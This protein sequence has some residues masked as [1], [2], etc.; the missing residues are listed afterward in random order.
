MANKKFVFQNMYMPIRISLPLKS[1]WLFWG[2]FFVEE[3]VVPFLFFALF[4]FT[5][6]YVII[7]TVVDLHM[8]V[9]I[10]TMYISTQ[11]K[12]WQK[13]FPKP[14][15]KMS[16]YSLTIPGGVGIAIYTMMWWA[17]FIYFFQQTTKWH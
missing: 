7:N 9:I 12:V 15:S 13:G 16:L 8:H 17:I 1:L 10:N 5:S 6:M 4:C 14:L 11:V 2:V 3:G